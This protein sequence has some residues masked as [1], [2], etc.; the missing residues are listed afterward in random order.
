M[1][2]RIRSKV[3]L[4]EE[5]GEILE[6]HTLTAFLPSIEHA[7]LIGDHEQLRPQIQN[8]DLSSE[9]PRGEKY[10]LDISTFERL[11]SQNNTGIP[12]DTLRT[13]R[14]MDPSISDL[15]RNTIYPDLLDHDSI[16]AYPEVVGMRKRLY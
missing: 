1:L 4:G 7:I 2:A 3:L 16:L 11:I 14:R 15:I 10:S 8:F 9:N 5:A 6:A 13:Q 12:Y